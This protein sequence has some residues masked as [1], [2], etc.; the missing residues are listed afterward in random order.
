LIDVAGNEK[1][2]KTMIQG[3]CSNNPDYVMILIDA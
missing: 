3:I 1:H 2:A